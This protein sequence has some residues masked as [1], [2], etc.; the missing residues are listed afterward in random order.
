ME[1]SHLRN[2]VTIADFGSITQAAHH[3]YLG[4]PSVSKSMKELEA[5]LGYAVFNR[6]SRG[7]VPTQQGLEFLTQARAVLHQ[8][9][10]MVPQQDTQQEVQKFVVYFPMIGYPVNAYFRWLNQKQDKPFCAHYYEADT[11]ST[12]EAVT[13]SQA[14]L[15]VIRYPLSRLKQF[16]QLMDVHQLHSA[17]L[18]DYHLQ[19]LVCEK[20]ALAKLQEVTL[21][22]L[23]DKVQVLCDDFAFLEQTNQ[24]LI[25]NNK[26]SVFQALHVIEKA[27]TWTTP[28][29]KEELS[30][31]QLCMKPC[32]QAPIYR[33][34]IIWKGVRGEQEN[35]LS[36]AL[37]QEVQSY[38][39][40]QEQMRLI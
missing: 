34:A 6:T 37:R 14:Q 4:Q 2:A 9:E 19:L 10:K 3:L 25:T 32:A 18:W 40:E 26:S 39:Y 16:E 1:L 17:P 20:S 24:K 38:V 35:L 28:L 12:I 7:V 30:I 33:D 31:H 27:Y 13:L 29:R 22:D 11:F 21:E 8:I 36:E 15:G 23:Q 5:E